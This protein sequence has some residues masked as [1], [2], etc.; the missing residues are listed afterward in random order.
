MIAAQVFLTMF[1]SFIP[2]PGAAGGAEGGFC[3]I[4]GLFFKANTIIPALFLWRVITYYS[5][6]GVG[7]LFSL[8]PNSKLKKCDIKQYL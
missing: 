7:A 5:C 1:M 8:I 2:L 4:F 3:M 6:I